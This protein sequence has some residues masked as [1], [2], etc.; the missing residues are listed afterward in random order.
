MHDRNNL[1]VTNPGGGEQQVFP[2]SLYQNSRFPNS[3]LLASAIARLYEL[4]VGVT[5][6]DEEAF[7]H[8][9]LEWTR[10]I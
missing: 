1:V 10:M 9:F 4:K 7:N 6:V 8:E 3:V 5:P 2:I